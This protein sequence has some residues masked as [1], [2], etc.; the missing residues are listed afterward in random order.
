MERA[1]RVLKDSTYYNRFMK[2]IENMDNQK[3]IVKEFLD[4]HDIETRE[5]YLGGNG[6]VNQPF[7]EIWK[8]DIDLYIVPTEKDKLRFDKVLCKPLEH[9][10]RKFK[11]SNKLLKEFQQY[12]IDNQVVINAHEDAPRDYFESIGLSGYSYSRVKIEDEIYLKISS[13]RLSKDEIPEGFEELKLSEY[14]KI[15]E[16]K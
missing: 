11:K 2:Y 4:K 16:G 6:A 10:L 14:Y 5:Y 7:I 12:C 13:H 3:K 8:S 9:G 15:I 1:F